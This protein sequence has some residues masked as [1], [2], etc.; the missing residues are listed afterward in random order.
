MRAAV[1]SRV[2]CALLVATT[3]AQAQGRPTP[4]SDAR[5]EGNYIEGLYAGAAGDYV[6]PTRRGGYG[7]TAEEEAEVFARKTMRRR[8]SPAAKWRRS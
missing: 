7:G 6:H 8:S 5:V 4:A 1:T 3:W 2:A